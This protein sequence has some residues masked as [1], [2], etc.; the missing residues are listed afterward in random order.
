M[1]FEFSILLDIYGELLT[2]NQQ[3]IM[4][5]RYDED[6]SL[7]E[8]GEIL[9]ISRQGVR[10]SICAA[11]ENLL[12]YEK[13]L[14]VAKKDREIKKIISSAESKNVDGEIIAALR[15]IAEE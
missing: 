2:E 1:D 6:F 14:G 8:I 10:N 9:S 13:K 11:E 4:K 7:A 5:M 15:M 3:K 12:N